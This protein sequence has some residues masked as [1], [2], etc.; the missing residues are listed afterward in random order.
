[1]C[2]IESRKAGVS[3]FKQFTAVRRYRW[4][5]NEQGEYRIVQEGALCWQPHRGVSAHMSRYTVLSVKKQCRKISIT[6]AGVWYTGL[7][8]NYLK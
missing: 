4:N 1:M 5:A 2:G 3:I 6:C 8:R 7:K